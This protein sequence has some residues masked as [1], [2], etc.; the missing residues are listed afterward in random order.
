[1]TLNDNKSKHMRFTNRKVSLNFIYNIN[2]KTIET[3]TKHKHLGILYDNKLSFNDHCNDI[4]HKSFSK[5]KFL[6]FI[7]RKTDCKT[8]LKL[9]KTY[10]L[11][12][13]EFSC[14]CWVPNKTQSDLLES[15]QRHITKYICYKSNNN[16]LTYEQRLNIL[17]LKSLK[18]RREINA[19][20]LVQKIKCNYNTIPINW[21]NYF[22][23]YNTTRNGILI[24]K[25]MKRIEMFDNFYFNYCINLY[26]SLNIDFRNYNNYKDFVQY[27]CNNY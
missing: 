6:K 22:Q 19:L 5:F 23:F 2:G 25:H 16:Y 12:I 24:K 15:I 18:H 3:V 7:C 13:I 27:L 26:N 9:Y 11:P 20:K 1:M 21:F 4:L 14:N 10:I 8:I 17:D